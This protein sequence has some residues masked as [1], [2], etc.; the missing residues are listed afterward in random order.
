MSCSGR[1]ITNK[2]RELTILIYFIGSDNPFFSEHSP[3]AS[4]IR[5]YV[6]QK[7]RS[8]SVSGYILVAH[9][10]LINNDS[11]RESRVESGGRH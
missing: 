8:I 3:R 9:I 5:Y 11:F 4:M 6:I 1:V 2:L 7:Q 10:I